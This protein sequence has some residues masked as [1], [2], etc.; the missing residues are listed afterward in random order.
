M[1]LLNG[2]TVENVKKYFF[3]TH[4]QFVL[5]QRHRQRIANNFCCITSVELNNRVN[6]TCA[7]IGFYSNGKFI[8]FIES[9][10]ILCII[11]L[12]VSLCL[13]NF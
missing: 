7:K 10:S 13:Q 6:V 12:Y 8:L 1:R 11:T 9:N 4:S 2:I 5:M 3:S